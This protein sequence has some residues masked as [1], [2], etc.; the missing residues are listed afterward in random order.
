MP[1]IISRGFAAAAT[2]PAT[3]CPRPV[4]DQ[5]LPR[6]LRRP[7]SAQAAAAVGLLDRR[8]GGRAA[9]LDLGGVPFLRRRLHDEQR[10]WGD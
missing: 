4:A 8:R 10:Y 6:P 3:A 2:R 7:D 5:R 1:P 9:P